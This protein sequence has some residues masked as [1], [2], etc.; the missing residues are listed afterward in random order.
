MK[1]Q[2]NIGILFGGRSCEHEVSV[3]SAR[4]ILNAM[5]RDKYQVHLI[6]IDKSG[7][8]HLA[9]NIDTIAATGSV[10][11]IKPASVNTPLAT[12]QSDN[13]RA[14]TTSV[15]LALHHQ[16]NLIAPATTTPHTENIK[17]PFIPTLDV[18]FPVLHGTFGEDGT[19]QGA[20]EMAGLP[21]V[22]C[23][24]AASALAMDKALAKKVFESADIT[25]A[26]YRVLTVWQWQQ[27]QSQLIDRIENDLGYAVFVKP[28]NLGSSVGISKACNR[29][30][31][32]TAIEHA[33]EFDNKIVIEQAMENCHEIECAI[34][35]NENPQASILGEIIAGA[36]FYNYKTKYIDDKSRSIIP[37]PIDVK[38]T[39]QVQKLAIK[40]FKAINGS[41]LA[42]V[43]FFVHK[44][45]QKIILNE[46]N[47][48]PGFTPISMYPQLWAASAIP[49]PELI[50]RL[51]D[52]ALS[53]HKS[54]Q[55]LKRAL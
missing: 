46:I 41:G 48:L 21:Y 23:T 50:D 14:P 40:A 5:D 51:I 33:L 54:K 32:I 34:L 45:S 19:L 47:T 4:S 16:G 26:P 10:H 44:D 1:N 35:G 30:E 38:T 29:N 6:G 24:V 31:L 43:D 49:Y 20:L 52:L 18:V 13:S 3:T 55:L 12:P 42:R 28:A 15:S 11:P 36:E 22:G 8:W 53:H 9:D 2:L 17:Q 27:Q 25:Q 7:Y 39:S 37:A